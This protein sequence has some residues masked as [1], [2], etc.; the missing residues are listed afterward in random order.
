MIR[1]ADK[2]S[3]IVVVDKTEYIHR[4]HNEMTDSES[5]KEIPEDLTETATKTVKKLVNKMYKDGV[6]NKDLKQYLIPKY[7]KK[8]KVKRKPKITQRRRT[9]Q[10]NCQW[11]QYSNRKNGRGRGIRAKRLCYKF[12][13]IY[14]RH[15]R[16]YKENYAKL[17][18]QFRRM[19]YFF[20]LM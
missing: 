20:V 19:L 12:T 3:G 16:F 18:R 11:R 17:N 10:N 7:P 6:I 1:P 8:Q 4:L 14:Q 5:Y 15:D 2:G 9:I 13:Y